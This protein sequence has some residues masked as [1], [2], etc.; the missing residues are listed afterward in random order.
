MDCEGCEVEIIE[1]FS[2][3][4][5]SEVDFLIEVHD[6]LRPNLGDRLIKKYIFTHD[7]VKIKPSSKKSKIKNYC[8]NV[9]YNQFSG[10]ELRSIV[11]EARPN[12]NYWLFFKSKFYDS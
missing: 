4:D 10:L 8:S 12:K 7:Y 9:F 1:K 5:L 11:D 3:F 6:F 2:S